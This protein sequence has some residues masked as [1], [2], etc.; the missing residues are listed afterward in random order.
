MRDALEDL[1]A[2]GF[3]SVMKE[4]IIRDGDWNG[5]RPGLVADLAVRGLWQPQTN[6]MFVSLTLM[7]S[8][9]AAAL[10]NR[11]FDLQKMKRS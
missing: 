5:E 2:M 4:P 8:I 7:Q 11:S 9:I 6:L 10:Y 3:S 1:M